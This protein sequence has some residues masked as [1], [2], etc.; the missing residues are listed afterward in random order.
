MITL[1][2]IKS[3]TNE[4]L[5]GFSGD[6]VWNF[7]VWNEIWVKGTGHWP[8]EYSGKFEPHYKLLKNPK[9]R[10]GSN[11]CYT[12]RE[13]KWFD[14]MWTSASSGNKKGTHLYWLRYRFCFC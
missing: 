14:A 4:P 2:T 8:A 13:F 5:E 9:L 6:S 3:E 7:H 12:T 11:R 1:E 10:M